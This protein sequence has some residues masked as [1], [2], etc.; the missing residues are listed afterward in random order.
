MSLSQST[1]AWILLPYQWEAFGIRA[2]PSYGLT[3]EQ[4]KEAALFWIILIHLIF[5]LSNMQSD[6]VKVIL[7]VV[8]SFFFVTNWTE[9]ASGMPRRVST[10]G[11]PWGHS[12]VLLM[13]IL[14]H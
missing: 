7:D 11:I 13:F 3:S 6:I 8:I 2:F 12:P 5:S 9:T 10:E 1:L 4:E 14:M